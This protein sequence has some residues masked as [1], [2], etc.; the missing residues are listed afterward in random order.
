M[1]STSLETTCS[2]S[3]TAVPGTWTWGFAMAVPFFK[4]PFFSVAKCSLVV[5]GVVHR[6]CE[7]AQL[8]GGVTIILSGAICPYHSD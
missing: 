2:N 8:K 3:G 6:L 7:P 4:A 1:L 5:F